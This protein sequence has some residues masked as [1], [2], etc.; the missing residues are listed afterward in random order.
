[1]GF[2][3]IFLVRQ[4]YCDAGLGKN[5]DSIIISWVGAV[6]NIVVTTR[7][8]RCFI[9]Y[10]MALLQYRCRHILSV[11]RESLAIA[12]IIL[13]VSARYLLVLIITDVR[14]IQ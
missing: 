2:K 11:Q 12:N 1:M 9:K 13:S 3:S 10:S 5:G 7:G 4:C 8:S 6:L 14:S